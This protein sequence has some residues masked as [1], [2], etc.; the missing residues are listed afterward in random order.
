MKKIVLV[1]GLIAGSIQAALI[2]IT[3]P[4]W[5]NGTITFDNGELVGY[6]TMVIA[7]SMV[8]FGIRSYRDRYNDGVIRFGKAFTV[9]LLIA[10]VA[11]VMYVVAWEISYQTF[12]SDFIDQMMAHQ[13]QKLKS[14]GASAEEVNAATRQ[15]EQYKSWYANPV[16]RVGLTLIET[17]PVGLILT[18]I[19]A[20]LL[21]RKETPLVQQSIH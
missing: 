2:F 7:F 14:G 11:S 10:L 19:S 8:F 9:G 13:V 5:K 4:L 16:I 1:Y 21:K 3:I 17:L 15:M 6:T 18:L 20:L 12:S